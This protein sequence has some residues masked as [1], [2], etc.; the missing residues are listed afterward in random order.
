MNYELL[1]IGGLWA[2]WCGDFILQTHHQA[3]TKSRN[4]ISLL[5]HCATYSA[6][7]C[8]WFVIFAKVPD[9]VIHTWNTMFFTLTTFLTHFI[10]DFFT[11]KHNSR[12]WNK[13]SWHNFFASVGLDQVIHYI[14]LFY[15]L[16]L[17]GLL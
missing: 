10:T 16:K 5:T 3:T 1:L 4:I 7:M 11:S 17:M 8:V 15:T 13:Q 14:T 9:P 6:V 2:H 12:L